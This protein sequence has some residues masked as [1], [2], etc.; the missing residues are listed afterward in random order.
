MPLKPPPL[1]SAP[2]LV[3]DWM[4]LKTLA[5]P[6]GQFRISSLKRQWDTN[7]E[8]EGTDPEGLDQREG[9]TDLDGVSGGD[10]DAYLDSIIEEIGDRIDALGES[11]PFRLDEGNKI[12]VVEPASDGGYSY[13]FCLFLTYANG[14]ELL[15]GSWLPAVDNRVRDLFQACS[16]VAAAGEVRG[17]AISF[18][19]PRPNTNPPFLTR[20]RQVYAIFGEGVVVQTPRKGVSPSPKDE[21]IDVIAWRPRADRAAGTEYLQSRGARSRTFIATGSSRHQPQQRRVR[22]SYRMR[23]HQQQTLALAENEWTR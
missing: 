21:E 17:C 22:S 12:V 4:E 2:Y 11:Y 16:T 13:F 20:L 3:C 19:W 14:R 9:D 1:K 5:S 10:E 8:S 7:R 23:S 6:T 18:G 15:D